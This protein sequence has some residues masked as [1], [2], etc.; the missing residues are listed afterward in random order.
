MF[1][2][3]QQAAR[4]LAERLRSY[5]GRRP[6]CLGIPRGGV[7]MAAAIAEALGG[8]VDVVLV[9]KLGAPDQ[10]EFAVG[11]V[12][13]EGRVTLSEGARRLGLSEAYLQQEGQAQLD[14]LRNRRALYTPVRPPIP[15]EGREVIVVDDGLATGATMM[16]ALQA[17]RARRPAR[18]VAATAVSPPETLEQVEA[19]ADEVVCLEVP[20]VFFAVGQFFMDFDQVEDDEVIAILKERGPGAG[21]EART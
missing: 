3:R 18:L 10:P 1:R 15:V 8:E 20:A 6:L 9:H 14:R 12:D 4:Q 21:T 17:L 13:E 19:L 2:D 7:V 16:A 5:A 11:A